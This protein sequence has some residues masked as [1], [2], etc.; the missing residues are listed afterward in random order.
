MRE[1]VSDLLRH[2][3]PPISSILVFALKML[4]VWTNNAALP[5]TL[6]DIT[7]WALLSFVMSCFWRVWTDK[8]SLA[9]AHEAEPGSPVELLLYA[10]RGVCFLLLL[11][12]V[13]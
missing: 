13:F 5:V 1:F 6:L 7:M 11:F 3:A 4:N 9:T 10:E 8:K 12:C 2:L